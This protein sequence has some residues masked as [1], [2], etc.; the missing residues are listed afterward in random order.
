MILTRLQ[1]PQDYIALGNRQ[2]F[3]LE[4]A[5]SENH[6]P[7]T[8][9]SAQELRA[10]DSTREQNVAKFRNLEHKTYVG[11]VLLQWLVSKA[12]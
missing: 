7:H 5:R 1:G 3:F 6:Q 9:I 4:E 11:Q 8:Q 12:S 10:A 2:K